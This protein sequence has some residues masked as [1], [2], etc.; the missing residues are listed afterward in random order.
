MTGVDAEQLAQGKV[1][2]QDNTESAWMRRTKGIA[3][4]IRIFSKQKFTIY[5]H[6]VVA[7]SR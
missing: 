1:R 2:K 5:Q 6:T 3:S 7:S 4:A